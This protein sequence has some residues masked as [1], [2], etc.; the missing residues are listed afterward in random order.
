MADM[1]DFANKVSLCIK[2]NNMEYLINLSLVF[3]LSIV[4]FLSHIIVYMYGLCWEILEEKKYQRYEVS[5]FA[6]GVSIK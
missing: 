6:R 2:H 4:T 1:Y 3:S 5:N